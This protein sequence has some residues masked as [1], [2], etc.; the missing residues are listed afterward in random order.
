MDQRFIVVKYASSKLIF[1]PRWNKWGPTPTW[2]CFAKIQIVLLLYFSFLLCEQISFLH[3]FAIK[4]LSWFSADSYM[5]HPLSL[6]CMAPQV[7][8]FQLLLCVC[9]SITACVSKCV[10]QRAH[11]SPP[12]SWELMPTLWQCR[13]GGAGLSRIDVSWRRF[14]VAHPCTLGTIKLKIIGSE[15]PPFI[16]PLESVNSQRHKRQRIQRQREEYTHTHTH[17]QKAGECV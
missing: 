17:K 3:L 10:L 9:V 1:M 6:W 5:K 11:H 2:N 8:T 15:S 14:V 13:D 4:Q 7:Y 12:E 16:D